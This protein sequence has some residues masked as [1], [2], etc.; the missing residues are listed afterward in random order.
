M[1]E[2]ETETDQEIISK[3]IGEKC[4]FKSIKIDLEQ[5]L[6]ERLCALR[7][8]DFEY[9]QLVEKSKLLKV[10][11]IQRDYEEKVEKESLLEEI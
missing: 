2:F 9:H 7:E 10:Q 5:Q 1:F 4:S 3:L 6:E 8:K 11:T